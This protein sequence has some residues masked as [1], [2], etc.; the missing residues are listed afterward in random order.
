[1]KKLSLVVIFSVMFCFTAFVPSTLYAKHGKDLTGISQADETLSAAFNNQQSDVQVYGKGKVVKILPDDMKGSKHQRFILKLASGQTV[2]VAHNI[3]LADRVAGLQVN[4]TVE[5]YG[6]YEWNSKGGVLHWTH[7]DPRGR[8]I[9][10]W[11]KHK[12]VRYE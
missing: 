2:L 1:M 7:H 12:G 8:H 3:D 5:F 9:D 10:G 11:L 6:E 4:D